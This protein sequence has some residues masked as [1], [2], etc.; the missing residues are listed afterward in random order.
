[1]RVAADELSYPLHVIVRVEIEQALVAGEIEVDDVPAWWNERLQRL[2][3]V[4]PQGPFSQGPLQDP[5]WVQGMFGYFPAYLLGAMVAAQAFAALRRDVPDLDTQVAA[6]NCR[7]LGDWLAPRFWQQGARHD[8]DP[9]MLHATG[10]PLSDTA[11][12]HHL[13]QRHGCSD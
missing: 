9:M 10:E 4:D 3:G 5:H 13:E 7:A 1:M 2:L 8:L 12:R 11:L 6:G